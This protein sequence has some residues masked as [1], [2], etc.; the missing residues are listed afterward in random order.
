[1]PSDFLS[2]LPEGYWAAEGIKF[3]VLFVVAFLTGV[4]VMRWDVRVNYTRKINHFVLFLFPL[5]LQGYFQ[6][7]RSLFTTTSS[8]LLLLLSFGLYM[9]PIR[10][11]VPPLATMFAAFDR[12]EDRP[13]SL[14]WLTSQVAAGYLVIIPMAV[15]FAYLG[16]PWLLFIPLLINGIGDGLA[17]P[18]GVRFGR[19]EY[20][21][22]PLNGDRTYVRTLEGSACV[23]LTAV[24][25]IA[26]FHGQFTTPQ[27][28]AA[29]LTVPVTMTLA[30]AW[31]PHTWDTP[32]L[33]LVGCLHLLAIVHFL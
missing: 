24:V 26:L 17:E 8:G 13:Y 19:H 18:V 6:F 21:T 9:G 27:F 14:W 32:F 28:W 4:M 11:R 2:H 7:D 20:R 25:V 23:F 16:H 10:S 29:M 5:W 31:S 3:A 1:M 30:E 22:R 33:L 15:L 12:P